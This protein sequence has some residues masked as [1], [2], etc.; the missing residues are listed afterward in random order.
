MFLNPLS[1]AKTD[2][3]TVCYPFKLTGKAVS[4]S[5]HNLVSSM[6]LLYDLVFQR[7]KLMKKFIYVI[8]ISFGVISMSEKGS[9]ALSAVAKSQNDYIF[10][11]S[12]LRDMNIMVDNFGT[13][14]QKKRFEDIRLLFKRSAERHY[15]REFVRS[16]SLSDDVKPDNNPQ[17]SLELFLQLKLQIASLF[18]DISKNYI[19]RSQMIM[20]STSRETNDILINYGK[21]TGNAKYF[22]RAIDPL[23]EKKPYKA[24]DYHYF[25]DKETLERYLK[26]GYKSLQ[27]AR[28]LSNNADFQYIKKK[29]NKTSVDLD[30]ILN[31]NLD[32]IQYC[33]QSKQYGIEMHRMLKIS[34]IGNIQKK[35][36]VTLGMINRNP[37]YDDR[38]PKE[39]KVDAIDNQKLLYKIEKVRLG[40]DENEPQSADTNQ[41]E[42]SPKK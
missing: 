33:R 8:M 16:D 10:L 37:I 23:N 19:D 22:Y 11:L 42:G 26:N 24:G 25:R 18:D 36:N 20:D 27:D 1:W 17:S 34:E 32:I 2:E 30:Y 13:E 14:D 15:A 41:K 39:Y 12:T 40:I 38:I 31:V 29:Q 21:N 28:N 35:Y 9:F 6:V 4:H 3:I 5:F 7:V